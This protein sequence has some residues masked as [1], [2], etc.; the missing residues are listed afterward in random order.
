MA[1][2]THISDA[3]G[4][5]LAARYDLAPFVR[6]EGIAA[7]SV[8]S[9]YALVTANGRYFLRI[10]EEQS[11]E[12]ALAEA[13]LLAHIAARGVPTA[14]PIP[15][16][17]GRVVSTT[18]G[19]AAVLFPWREGGMRCQASVS[20]DDMRRLG[21]ALAQ[22]HVAGEGAARPPGRFELERLAEERLAA[23]SSSATYRGEV[24]W[25]REAVAR[26]SA[27]R[28]ALL[29]R[30]LV[31]GDLFR[32]NVLWSADG[33]VAALLDF[34]SASDGTFVYD[35]MVTALA[36]C[37]G[38]DFD[39]RLFRAMLDGY[40]A[41]R[42]LSDAERRALHAEG[43]AAALRFTMTRLTDYAMRV[44]DGPRVVKDWRRFKK[45]FDTLDAFD[46]ERF[47]AFVGERST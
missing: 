11:L 6:L 24:G 16:R 4:E 17:D 45:R 30:G 40:K 29:P 47:L 8:N 14:A 37:V 12:G 44:T 36:W 1:V 33:A 7:G 21:A 9:N 25:L 46:A 18:T 10:Y 38:D 2:L 43:C 32:D 34:E 23:I 26:V 3:Q 27:Q 13:A 35:I 5:A 41:I 22:I 19:K 31:H 15:L 42:R 28:D 39:P 20:D